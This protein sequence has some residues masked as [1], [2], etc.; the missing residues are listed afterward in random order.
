MQSE[1]SGAVALSPRPLA[2]K[3]RSPMLQSALGGALLGAFLSVSAPR[4]ARAEKND[5]VLARLGERVGDRVVGSNVDFR[6]MSSQLGVAL[7]PHLLEPADTLGFGGFE[8]IA[9]LSYTSIDSD[10]SYWRALESSPGD[11]AASH[12][13]S[14]LSTAGL[15]VRK[16]IWLPLPSFEVGAGAVHLGDSKIWAAQGYAKFAIHEGYHD[17]PLPS[18]AIRGAGSRMMGSEELD[19][20]VGSLDVTASKDFGIAGALT[21]SPYGGWNWL[22]IVARSEVIDKT[23]HIDVRSNPEDA[24]M[25][26]IFVDQDTILRNRMFVGGKLKYSVV[27]FHLEGA[28]AL[29]G[30]STD[31]RGGTDLDCGD[32]DAP[33]SA[34]DATDEA[35]AQTTLTLGLGLD[36]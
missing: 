8:F 30:S 11:D 19:L 20:T 35:G 14:T 3:L 4:D 1:R 34:C 5:L 12:G 13:S 10:A 23:P 26:F 25:N 7:A 6:S 21:V 15:F 22:F 17:L 16:G 24:R 2:P 32:L 28:L 9:D 29:A 36:F 33:T 31:E 27:T 18:L